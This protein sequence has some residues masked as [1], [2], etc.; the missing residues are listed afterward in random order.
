MKTSLIIPCTPKHFVSNIVETL[1]SYENGSIKPDEVIISLSQYSEVKN[2]VNKKD[3]EYLEKCSS[4]KVFDKFRILMHPGI[5]T[6]GPNRQEGSRV[7]NNEIL[8]Y[9]DADDVACEQRIEVIKYFF[10]NLD[11]CHLNHQWINDRK[12]FKNIEPSKIKYINSET[13]YKHYFP[14]NKIE[15][16]ISVNSSYGGDLLKYTTTGHVS[17]KKNVLERIRWKDWSEFSFG[18]AEDYEFC[19]EALFYYKKS[20]LI[21]APLIEYSNAGWLKENFEQCYN[22]L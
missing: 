6:H 11:I 4:N 20:I 2:N 12:N 18:P 5:K 14:N 13:L 21:N 16:C 17:I 7:A 22:I 10:E 19:M 9:G 15:D 3:L 8:I 1:K